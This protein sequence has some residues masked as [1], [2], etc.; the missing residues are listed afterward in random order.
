MKQTALLV[1]AIVLLISVVGCKGK[2]TVKSNPDCIDCP[3]K[4]ESA[5]TDTLG[6]QPQCTIDIDDKEFTILA[7]SIS[8]AYTFSDSSLTIT[9]LGVGGGLVRLD[10]PNIYK[11]PCRIPTGYTSPRFKEYGSE[12]YSTEPTVYLQK[13]PQPGLSFNNLVDGHTKTA[14]K[15]N[16][17]E[18]SSIRKIDEN[19]S[20]KWAVY[21]IK[22]MINTTVFKSSYEA[23]GNDRNYEVSGRFVIQTKIDY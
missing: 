21:L 14:V 20:N 12:T 8:T 19:T 1:A 4:K 2:A 5:N 17:F 15:D 10:I 11:C 23:S 9:F 13:Y 16:A 22:G 18:I 3:A 7:D 6:N